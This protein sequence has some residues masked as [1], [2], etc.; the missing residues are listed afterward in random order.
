MGQAGAEP[1]TGVC[2]WRRWRL[3]GTSPGCRRQHQNKAGKRWSGREAACGQTEEEGR[4]SNGP[5][6]VRMALSLA[7]CC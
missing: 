6:R 1:V 7:L 3:S 4:L 2:G 5:E